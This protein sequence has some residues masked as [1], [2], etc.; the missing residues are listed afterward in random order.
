MA[1]Q[2]VGSYRQFFDVDKKYFP[3]I[4]DSAISAG[5]HMGKYISS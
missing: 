1:A 4:D 5:A 3:C 2:E